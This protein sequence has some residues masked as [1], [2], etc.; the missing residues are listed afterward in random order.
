MLWRLCFKRIQVM[1]SEA[2]THLFLFFLEFD[3]HVDELGDFLLLLNVVLE[4]LR[5]LVR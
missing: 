4:F 2:C 1:I 5:D 3:D